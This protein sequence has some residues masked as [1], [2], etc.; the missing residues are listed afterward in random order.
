MIASIKH[1]PSLVSHNSVA[2]V[3]TCIDMSGVVMQAKGEKPQNV[4]ED[5]RERAYLTSVDGK[6]KVSFLE[7]KWV[8]KC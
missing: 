3:E 5:S 1:L 4:G 8:T 6:L 2:T 7:H